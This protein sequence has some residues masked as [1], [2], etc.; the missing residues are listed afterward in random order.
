MPGTEEVLEDL[1]DAVLNGALIDWAAAESSAGAAVQPFVRELRLVASVAQVY[2]DVMPVA[3]PA[4]WGH[5]RLL[6]RIG[7][8]AFGEV[9]RAFDTRLDREVALK[10]LPAAPA[11]HQLVA[12]SI[13]QEGRLLAKVRH[14]NVVTIHGA[15]Q[16]G[17]RVGLWMEFVRGHTLEQLLQ[18][19]TV[20][21]TDEVISIGIEVCRA[22]SAVHAAG[23]LHRDIKAH[24]VMRAED[25]RIMLMDFGTGRE[26]DDNSPADVAGT[27]LYLAP[28]LLREAPATV[29]T[30][31]YSLGVLLYHLVSGSY[32]VRGGSVRELRAAHERDERVSARE[33]HPS[34]HAGLARLIDQAIDPR[35]ERRPHT[36]DALGDGLLK[37]RQQARM[38]PL[39]YAAA[40]VAT[41]AITG[42]TAW[43]F[44]WWQA[45]S[46]ANPQT[47][48]AAGPASAP[49]AT[50]APPLAP[51]PAASQPSSTARTVP[52]P[53]SVPGQVRPKGLRPSVQ[54]LPFGNASGRSADAWLSAT[55]TEMLLREFRAG[56]T[57]RWIPGAV[58]LAKAQLGLALT[59]EGTQALRPIIPADIIVA[60]E[61]RVLGQ[62]AGIG[63]TVRIEDTVSGRAPTFVSETG[64]TADLVGLVSRI[65]TKARSGLGAPMLT[66]S[67]TIALGSSQPA[68]AEAARA[69]VEGLAK[70]PRE[71][72]ELMEQAIVAD[73][74]FAP[75][76][77]ALAEGLM[78]RRELEKAR[79][80]AA[81]AVELSV[82]FPR[83]ERMLIEVRSIIAGGGGLKTI[84][85][86]EEIFR[87]LFRLFPDTVLYG[88]ESARA[89][90]RAQQ[91][92]EGL[93]TVEA[94]SHLPGASSDIGLLQLEAGMARSTRDYP[95]AQQ[96]LEKVAAIATAS[97]DRPLLGFIRNNQ[98][99]LAL[100]FGELAKASSFAEEAQQLGSAVAGVTIVSIRRTQGDIARARAGYE[101]L[102]ERA[103]ASGNRASEGNFRYNL[104][105]MLSDHGDLSDA[106]TVWEELLRDFAP[107]AQPY[108]AAAT[109]TGLGLVLYRQGE[110]GAA[111]K[112]FEEAQSD[113][114]MAR[115]LLEQAEVVLA[116]EYATRSAQVV[117]GAAKGPPDDLSSTLSIL[118]RTL[119]AAGETAAARQA[120]DEAAPLARVTGRSRSAAGDV[121]LVRAV[122]ALDEG[123]WSDGRSAAQQAIALARGDFR[124]DDEAAGE[125]I[126]GLA[127]LGEGNLA[128]AQ[129]AIVRVEQRLKVT[130]DRLL[131]LSGGIVVARVRA[132]ANA[133][134]S[135]ALARR[136]LE[137]L[138]RDAAGLGAVAIAFD[139]RLALGEI[140]IKA[141]DAAVGRA[142][143]S[144][145]ARDAA[146]KG[147]VS[148]AKKAA[149][150]AKG[151][152][153]KPGARHDR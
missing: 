133:P 99:T 10:L 28:E 29:Q 55:L 88:V 113:D 101:Q 91:F 132:A 83:E 7:Y 114:R 93:A 76:H 136:Q 102:I 62:P 152:A 51:P 78:F 120:I 60:G 6:E 130:E 23:L 58:A 124:P 121:A 75:A 37:L 151:G 87:Q 65:G 9:F 2:R 52:K 4:Q 122:L 92:Q 105:Y 46:S 26:L 25:R 142:H 47:L 53:A 150:A 16:I 77:I 24:N 33:A 147:F 12:S 35:P 110:F 153:P 70:T 18:Q 100:D 148:V 96:A 118:A 54:V 139:A 95:R 144:E 3:T 98:A 141:G 89:Q 107:N 84:E 138:S 39:L 44:R 131:R 86:R 22:V 90:S 140:E 80:A 73:P 56:E 1:E 20:F 14:P 61:F 145:L 134:G 128:E 104:A 129:R 42:V 127:W 64:T 63:L 68:N 31:V 43:A 67:Q 27:P 48:A 71:A 41:L 112:K 17:E 45:P 49:A 74:R 109:L 125:G 149:A 50:P 94:V 81:R 59:S 108:G 11:S 106:R 15:E 8:G 97:G 119:L 126:L 103:K 32:P 116:R 79:T 5:L 21:R 117:R 38:R 57:F 137:A 13:I 146:A 123:R 85:A 66:P 111:W 40:A 34:I 30:D 72:V 115:L 135:T 19:G 36:A 69:F 143:L 82:D